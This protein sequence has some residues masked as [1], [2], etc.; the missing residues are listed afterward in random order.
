MTHYDFCIDHDRIRRGIKHRCCDNPEVL[1]KSNNKIK[2]MFVHLLHARVAAESNCNYEFEQIY[3]P[4]CNLLELAIPEEILQEIES[5]EIGP[6]ACR[7]MQKMVC[8]AGITSSFKVREETTSPITSGTI[9]VLPEGATYTIGND[10]L[11]VYYNG[12]L[13]Y[14]GPTCDYVETSPNSIEFLFTLRANSQ[15][16]YVIRT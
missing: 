3:S 11:D 5:L 9:H 7:Y 2:D 12:Q 10:S 15:L 4:D 14:E 6:K 8:L 16:Q 1:A 13:L